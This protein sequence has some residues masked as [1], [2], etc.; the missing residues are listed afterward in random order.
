[1]EAPKE[2]INLK[3]IKLRHFDFWLFTSVI[4]LLSMGLLIVFSA[5]APSSASRYNGDVYF[6]FRNQLKHALLGILTMLIMS[7]IPYRVWRKLAIPIALLCLGLLVVVI[8][9]GM[10]SLTKNTR[11]WM[12]I[13]S[14]NFQPS[15]LA[16]F[17]LVCFLAASLAVHRDRLKKFF[18]GFLPYLAVVLTFTGLIL[19]EP[20]LS[21]SIIVIAVGAI[22]MFSAGAR[23]WHFIVMAVP[24]SAGGIFCLLYVPRFEYMKDRM[25]AFLDPWKDRTGDGYQIIQSM[26]AIGSGGLFGK[27][28]GKSMQK[29]LYIPE[30]HNDFIFSILAEELG[31]V[32]VLTVLILFVILFWRG[33]KISN[34]ADD[35][36]GSLLAIGLTSLIAVQSIFNIAV[37]TASVPVTGV[38]LP[39]FSYGGTSLILFLS[40]V[41]ILLNISKN[42]NV[43]TVLSPVEIGEAKRTVNKA[44][45]A[46]I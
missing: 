14:F 33:V 39:F 11:R 23:I 9:P 29:F 34:M 5:S 42:T 20:H 26:Y 24:I 3:K 6:I 10:S 19:V 36:F 41:G 32:G 4:L 18:K 45:K 28:L 44:I 30:P 17:G 25:V 16:K 43:D 37:V 1:M 31:F 12:Y 7:F 22:V 13:G 38:S 40:E 46:G 21:G 35:A 2:K 27:G 15:E 8:L